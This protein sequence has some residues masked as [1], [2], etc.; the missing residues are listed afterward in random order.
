[1]KKA[2]QRGEEAFVPPPRAER[3][4]AAK[5]EP[6]PAAKASA[7]PLPRGQRGKAKKMAK[8]AEQDETERELRMLLTGSTTRKRDVVA[9]ARGVVE[10][11]VEA[12]D[13][14]GQEEAP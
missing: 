5:P 9:A 1:M 6:K 12:P 2:K 4:P 7:A 11:E 14:A 13:E 8:Y 3:E 10:K